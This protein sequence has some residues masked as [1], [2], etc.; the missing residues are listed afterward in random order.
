MVRRSA[1][2]L[3]SAE[4]THLHTPSASA[5]RDV[6]VRTIEMQAT[7]A[8]HYTAHRLHAT[9]GEV[10]A[11]FSNFAVGD[12]GCAASVSLA[13]RDHAAFALRKE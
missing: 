13:V 2:G 5:R 11:L 8:Y 1:L 9:L 3:G 10:G 6:R 12:G 7:H 4:R